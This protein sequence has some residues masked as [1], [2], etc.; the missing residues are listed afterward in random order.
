[1]VRDYGERPL[2]GMWLHAP[3]WAVTEIAG[4]ILR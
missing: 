4:S 3:T 1:M 2:L